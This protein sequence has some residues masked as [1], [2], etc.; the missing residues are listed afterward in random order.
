[1][2]DLVVVVKP[3]R[4]V[5]LKGLRMFVKDKEKVDPA[6]MT[7]LML[8]TVKVLELSVQPTICVAK[9]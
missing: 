4:A 2:D 3:E 8:V 5:K 1:M 9:L 6:A 7:E